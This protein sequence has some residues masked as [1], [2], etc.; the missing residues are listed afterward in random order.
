M[1]KQEK[2]SNQTD[3]IIR[4]FTDGSGCRPDGEGSGFSWLREDNGARKV[5]REPG[6][7][8]N[9]AEYRAILSAVESLT[10]GEKAEILTDSENTCFQLKGER[11]VK[12]PHL[13][14]LHAEIQTAIAE[15]RL[16]VIFTWIPR[17]DNRAGKLI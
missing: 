16:T 1:K 5:V 13:A 15:N 6:L 8:N 14:K 17:R 4:I 2:Q 3:R 7:T 9:Q 12:D 10:Q 11:R